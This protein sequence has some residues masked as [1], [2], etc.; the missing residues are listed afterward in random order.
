MYVDKIMN[1][2]ATANG[3]IL[4]SPFENISVVD[5]I[6]K[7]MTDALILGELKP[8]QKIPTEMELCESMQVGRNSVR[9]A[10]KILSAMGVVE[11]RRSEG[12][13]VCQGFSSRML[14][15]IIYG[16]I[17]EG[18]DSHK[19]IELRRLF[20]IGILELLVAKSDGQITARLETALEELS[21]VV[22][23]CDDVDVILD[24][25]IQF[26]MT[27]EKSFG[28]PLVDKLSIVINRLTRPTR[29]LA[30]RHFIE[31]G[32]REELIK[33]HEELFNIVKDRDSASIGKAIDEHF[34]YWSHAVK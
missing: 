15:P 5:R 14:D 30:V 27:L 7:R 23:A 17:L 25:D 10:I 33:R 32:Q 12:T 19:I 21:H 6:I 13:F 18:G 4:L 16:M 3:N 24:A 22:R 9:E 2:D 20:D 29:M 1:Q 8:G 11:I 28:N 26:H 34:K 31:S